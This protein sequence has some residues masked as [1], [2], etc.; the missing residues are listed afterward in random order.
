VHH[1]FVH[2]ADR[3]LLAA[4]AVTLA[5]MIVALRTLPGSARAP[6]RAVAEQPAH[7]TA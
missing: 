3:G 6:R 4:A 5:G 2:A 7:A 1:A